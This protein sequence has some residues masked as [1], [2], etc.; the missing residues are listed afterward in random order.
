LLEALVGQLPGHREWFGT[1]IIPADLDV[2][3]VE[4]GEDLRKAFDLLYDR[5]ERSRA[6][7]RR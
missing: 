3:I 5:F 1:T 2:A 7:A 6:G 4:A